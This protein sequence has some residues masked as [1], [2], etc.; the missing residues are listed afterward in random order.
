MKLGK[1]IL[2]LLIESMCSL[3]L[4]LLEPLEYARLAWV[5][6]HRNSHGMSLKWTWPMDSEF[7]D[8]LKKANMLKSSKG[9]QLVLYVIRLEYSV[10]QYIC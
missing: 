1:G 5:S 3:N 6:K 2:F 10:R 8:S 7:A 4:C 9:F